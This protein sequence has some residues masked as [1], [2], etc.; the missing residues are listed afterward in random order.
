MLV[1]GGNNA[2]QLHFGL[3]NFRRNCR[4]LYCPR[5]ERSCFGLFGWRMGGLRSHQPLSISHNASG[6]NEV[7]MKTK[8]QIGPLV[9]LLLIA[10]PWAV[11]IIGWLVVKS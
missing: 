9:G 5:Q 7:V 11:A 4:G 3:W 10:A 6:I 1:S 8:P 2:N